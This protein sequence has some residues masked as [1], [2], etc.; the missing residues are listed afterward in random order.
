MSA[1]I[2]N[3]RYY[4]ISALYNKVVRRAK[5]DSFVSGSNEHKR[6]L[7]FSS[8]VIFMTVERKVRGYDELTSIA[9]NMLT[10]TFPL[11]S[12]R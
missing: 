11:Q 7:C 10:K 3:L 6:Y 4:T 8:N 1:T 9:F 2:I 5:D 12:H